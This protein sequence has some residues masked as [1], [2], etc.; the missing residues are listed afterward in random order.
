MNELEHLITKLP[1]CARESEAQVL[2]S[3]F[4]GGADVMAKA[5]SLLQAEDF[6]QSSS[7]MIYRAALDL[8]Q[9]NQPIDVTTVSAELKEQGRLDEVGGYSYMNELLGAVATI[10]AF[11]YH[12]GLVRDKANLRAVI[13][14][15]T[16]A[17][18]NAHDDNAKSE[19]VIT[20]MSDLIADVTERSCVGR[21]KP[22]HVQQAADNYIEVLKYQR[23]EGIVPGITTGYS[24]LDE[25]IRFKPGQLIV[26][27]ARPSLGKSA[28][29]L[30]SAFRSAQCGNKVLMYSLE[31]PKLEIM[32]RLIS[33]L[34]GVSGDVLSHPPSLTDFDI[35]K[36]DKAR[37]RIDAVSF[38]VADEPSETVAKIA[39]KA[40]QARSEMGGLDAIYVDYL[41]LIGSDNSK[42]LGNRTEE[43]SAISRG[44][45]VL[46]MNMQVP[47]IAL[48]QL[49]R[50]SEVRQNKR[51]VL[52][53]LRESGSIEQ[54][55]DAAVFLHREEEDKSRI[56]MLVL[57]N[58]GGRL[59]EFKLTW[60]GHTTTFKASTDLV[61]EQ[62]G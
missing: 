59:G 17:I 60:M 11:E 12:C 25:Y 34:S 24:D 61:F 35:L 51:P 33:V 39:A 48:S 32:Q 58:R 62:A 14:L 45:K 53:D 41:Q 55:A 6:Y 10:A 27:A 38:M 57:K 47:V 40:R 1:P 26:L 19:K 9:S 15:A 42:K 18:Q 2:G 54:D 22:V 29:A 44:L 23:A 49:N 21:Y 8:F 56:E 20:Q 43:V 28:F 31:M 7:R 52:S 13:G 46:A 50:L 4:L 16:A 5:I 3:I 36:I 30:Q 37:Q